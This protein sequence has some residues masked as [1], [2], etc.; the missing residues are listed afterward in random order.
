M[1]LEPTEEG[2]ERVLGRLKTLRRD[3][4]HLRSQCVVN[5]FGIGEIHILYTVYLLCC[6]LHRSSATYDHVAE[7]MLGDVLFLRVPIYRADN[8]VPFS[9]EL[10]AR[11]H[12]VRIL[13]SMSKR[14]LLNDASAGVSRPEDEAEARQLFLDD[15]QPDAASYIQKQHRV[16][17]RILDASCALEEHARAHASSRA[18]L[19]QRS[20]EELFRRL[21]RRLNRLSEHTEMRQARRERLLNLGVAATVRSMAHVDPGLAQKMYSSLRSSKHRPRVRHSRMFK[22]LANNNERLHLVNFL[23]AQGGR[24]PHYYMRKLDQYFGGDKL[25]F[26]GRQTGFILERKG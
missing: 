7:Q 14:G 4:E 12:A 10:K 19:D 9:L 16:A 18:P 8:L 24:N 26:A 2:S 15:L 20:P 21:R 25:R 22:L 6:G 23:Y 17:F 13:R 3:F 1:I 5:R 11:Y